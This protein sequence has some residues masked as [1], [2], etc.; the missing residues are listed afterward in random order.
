MK[1]GYS[2]IHGTMIEDRFMKMFK[3]EKSY[4]DEIDFETSNCLYE[5]KSCK[6]FNDCVNGNDQRKPHHKKITTSQMGRFQV[7]TNNHIMLYLRAMQAG[8]TAK[9]I[10]AV[11]YGKQVIFR[12]MR[13]E[14]LEVCNLRD[15]YYVLLKDIFGEL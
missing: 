5:V 6:L 15:Y 7:I 14:E 13:W 11:R 2:K 1:Q 4:L 12:V 9:Y 3:G 8:K 10:F